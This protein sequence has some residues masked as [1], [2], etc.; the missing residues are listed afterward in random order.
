M[1]VN[2]NTR[3]FGSNFDPKVENKLRARQALAESSNPNDSIDFK[4]ING[5]TVSISDVIKN[6]S[7]ESAYDNTNAFVADLSSRTPWARAWVAVEIFT[8]KPEIVNKTVKFERA[9]ME[10]D[11]EFTTR[12]QKDGV[13]YHVGGNEK[14]VVRDRYWTARDETQAEQ[15]TTMEKKVYV[16]GDNNYDLFDGQQNLYDPISG[17]NS[18]T[19]LDKTISTSDIFKTELENNV[20]M[21]PHSGITS[22]TSKTDGPLGAI[23]YTTVNFTVHSFDDFQNIYS[24]FF[25]KP[26]ATIFVDFG[27]N[28]SH[29]YDPQSIFEG[30]E[31]PIEKIYGTEGHVHKS[32]GDLEVV[33]G[34]VTDFNADLDEN[35]SYICSITIASDN[36]SLVDH[37]VS[38]EN[39]VKSLLVD[40]LSIIIINKIAEMLGEGFIKNDWTSEELTAEGSKNYANSFA[41]KILG[42]TKSSTQIS[43]D[44][45]KLGVYWQSLGTDRISTE[46]SAFGNDSYVN[47]SADGVRS[48]RADSAISDDTNLYC[49]WAFF[50]EEILNKEFGFVV[51]EGDFGGKFDSTN[52]F[53]THDANLKERQNISYL[54]SKKKT[55]FKFL[56]PESWKEG[57]TYDTINHKK[58]KN[59]YRPDFTRAQELSGQSLNSEFDTFSSD[60]DSK[61]IPFRELFI[62]IKVISDAFD[63]NSNVSS[64]IIEILNNLN[65]DSQNVFNLKL[66]SGN[67]DNSMM[68]IV[69]TNFYNSEYDEINDKFDNLF[70]FKPYSKGSIVKEMSL[71]Y[72][73]PNNATQTMIA[74][75]NKSANIPIFPSTFMENKNQ[76]L[77]TI[78]QIL[79]DDDR[80]LGVRHLPLLNT[81][82]KN[83]Q[84][85]KAANSSLPT[86]G[87]MDILEGNTSAESIVEQYLEISKKAT[88]YKNGEGEPLYIATEPP[89][90]S[91]TTDDETEIEYSDEP[92]D[93]ID[94]QSYYAKNIE[95]Y[96]EYKI[97]NDF[98]NSSTSTPLPM[99]L[100]LTTYGLSGVVPGDIF[101]VDY[102]PSQYKNRV[103]FQVTNVEQTIDE[104]GWQTSFET[105][106]RVRQDKIIKT[107]YKNPQNIYIARSWLESIRV[108]PLILEAFKNFK[109][110]SATDSGVLVFN[111]MGRKRMKFLPS[112]TFTKYDAWIE[113]A[114]PISLKIGSKELNVEFDKDYIITLAVGG[115]FAWESDDVGNLVEKIN[116]MKDELSKYLIS[117]KWRGGGQEYS[118]SVVSQQ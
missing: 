101:T 10:T 77:R 89:E 5:E 26:G 52:S 64:A 75:Q 63:T 51:S 20:L 102:L 30:G 31:D 88:E 39:K 42:S 32:A 57:E 111:V 35:G 71:S 103:Y 108:N 55:G 28:T 62:N 18:I 8:H 93:I 118:D 43:T 94:P 16:L 70:E 98:I 66:I 56:Y 11:D 105:Q 95:E 74:V 67:R 49:S 48:T 115:A 17:K 83:L 97:R 114:G 116:I 36:A 25:L 68:T 54:Y 12:I 40:N 4:K 61:R 2:F 19:D 79:D 60:I 44:A 106:M 13:S 14:R 110:N 96:Y 84:I 47:I 29:S 104:S 23:K 46:K 3:I 99:D 81:D 22:V 107:L 69:D 24:K 113:F 38:D 92:E 9:H 112:K 34:K 21:K 45:S 100:K 80:K 53:V 6:H 58:S 33:V 27:W 59:R 85:E 91:D 87:E 15:S 73:T 65:Q 82:N 90:D 1:A 76:A 109:L 37:E 117:D 72:T 41:N 50:E 86:I 7:F 78:Y